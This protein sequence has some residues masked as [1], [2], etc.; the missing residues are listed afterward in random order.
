MDK[1]AELRPEVPV[2]IEKYL[3]IDSEADIITLLDEE[4]EK[5]LENIKEMLKFKFEREIK[6]LVK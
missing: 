5:K 6:A 4:L 1:P 2:E 3:A